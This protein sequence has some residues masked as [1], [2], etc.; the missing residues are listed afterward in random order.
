MK[1]DLR[2]H[3]RMYQEFMRTV[4]QDRHFTEPFE[5]RFRKAVTSIHNGFPNQGGSSSVS[6]D[7]SKESSVDSTPAS[8]Q[9]DDDGGEGDGEPASRRFLLHP[10]QSPLLTFSHLSQYVT[11]GR[12]RIYQLIADPDFQ[13]PPPVKFGKSSRW[14]RAEVDSWLAKQA[15]SRHQVAEK[16]ALTATKMNGAPKKKGSA[17]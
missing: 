2:T 12:S 4:M 1:S 7:Q 16:P 15:N 10:P 8:E 9:D 11:F 17:K 3:E 14:L 6:F 5:S 13:F